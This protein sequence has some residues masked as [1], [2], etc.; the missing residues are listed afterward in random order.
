[1]RI[2]SLFFKT[3]T[4]QQSK[5]NINT[6]CTI[7]RCL[8]QAILVNSELHT[9]T[10]ACGRTDLKEMYTVLSVHVFAVSNVCCV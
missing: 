1:M 6:Q 3:E 10:N 7:H 4:L 9:N 2:Q 5:K 8:Y